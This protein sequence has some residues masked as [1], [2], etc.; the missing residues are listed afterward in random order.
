[1]AEIQKRWEERGLTIALE[2]MRA[3]GCYAIQDK[4][5]VVDPNGYRNFRPEA[6]VS[7]HRR[8]KRNAQWRD[9]DE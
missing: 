3:N 1:V 2:N 8:Y 9:F 6:G 5:R 4:V 7:Y